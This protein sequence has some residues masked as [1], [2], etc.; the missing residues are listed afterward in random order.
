[1]IDLKALLAR[2]EEPCRSAVSR[3]VKEAAVEREPPVA[4]G[5]AEG[6]SGKATLE[7]LD[8]LELA[9]RAIVKAVL[10]DGFVARLRHV[11]LEAR[12]IRA[13]LATAEREFGEQAFLADANVTLAQGWTQAGEGGKA[14]LFVDD[15]ETAVIEARR[16]RD[17]LDELN[18]YG[19]ALL[20]EDLELAEA[21]R[22][23]RA[24]F[25]GA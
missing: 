9:D 6:P 11:G 7:A 16:V 14:A 4:S 1:M 17:R 2:L 18:A 22:S 23:R 19:R 8:E 10:D 3:A 20:D 24:H 13:D 25:E 12:R 15:A 21:I 5:M